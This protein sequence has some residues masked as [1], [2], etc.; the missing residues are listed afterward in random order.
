[1]ALSEFALPE[2][3]QITNSLHTHRRHNWCKSERHQLFVWML[4][5]DSY[6]E[7]SRSIL[8]DFL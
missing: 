4:H 7:G 1:M 6:C 3:T 5:H 8:E 2:D